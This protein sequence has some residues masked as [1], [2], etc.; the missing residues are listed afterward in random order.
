[1]PALLPETTIVKESASGGIVALIVTAV[2]AV[3]ST[4]LMLLPGVVGL[5]EVLGDTVAQIL[6]GAGAL[7]FGTLAAFSVRH[8]NRLEPRLQLTAAGLSDTSALVKHTNIPWSEVA[9]VRVETDGFNG[10]KHICLM[11]HN[12]KKYVVEKE[13]RFSRNLSRVNFKR[14]GTP[15]VLTAA[16][17]AISHGELLHLITAYRQ[18]ALPE[19]TQ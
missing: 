14:F 18:Q 5:A 8:L 7:L 3:A 4:I 1:M 2:L 6:G 10:L 12:P 13:G 16:N 9:D 11:L 17:L 15:I 19:K